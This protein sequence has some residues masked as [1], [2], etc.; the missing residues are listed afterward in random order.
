[1]TY[2]KKTTSWGVFKE[3]KDK[4]HLSLPLSL[5]ESAS[6]SVTSQEVKLPKES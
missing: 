1:M 2:Q 5:R 6:I 4:H 3:R